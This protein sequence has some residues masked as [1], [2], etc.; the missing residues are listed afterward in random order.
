MRNLEIK[1]MGFMAGLVFGAGA[2]ADVMTHGEYESTEK[3]IESEYKVARSRCESL[4]GNAEDICEAEARGNASIAKAELRARYDPSAKHDR[5][6]TNARAEAAYAVAI[7]RCDGRAGDD[8]DA[9]VKAAE[10]T[11]VHAMSD[12]SARM[13]GR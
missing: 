10:A 3:R 9:C 6:V 11:K 5:T 12:A 2:M 1:A 13:E 8:K 7:E 4:A